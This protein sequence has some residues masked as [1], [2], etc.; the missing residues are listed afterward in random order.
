MRLMFFIAAM[1]GRR[2]FGW[3]LVLF[4]IYCVLALYAITR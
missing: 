1:F 4:A 2:F 3:F